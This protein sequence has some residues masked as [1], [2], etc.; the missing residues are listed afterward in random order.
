MAERAR[1]KVRC[2]NRATRTIVLVSCKIV[3]YQY[4]HLLILV[5][6]IFGLL[7]KF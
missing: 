1:E 2:A 3:Q 7:F 6:A 4:S 5:T